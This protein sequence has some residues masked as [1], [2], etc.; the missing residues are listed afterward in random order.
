MPKGKSNTNV[1]QLFFE[2]APDALFLIN[3]DGFIEQINVQATLLFGYSREE[4]IGKGVE[5]LLPLGLRDGHVN[6]RKLYLEKPKLRPMGSGL[7]LQGRAKNGNEFPIDVSLSPVEYD[8][9]MMIAAAVRDF[10]QQ[11]AAET[12]LRHAKERAQAA[13]ASKSRFLAAASHDLRQPLQS[14]N[15]YIATL[16]RQTSEVTVLETAGKMHQS[17]KAM[18]QLL[19]SLLDLS[20]FEG[21]T[22]IPKI[23]EFPAQ[24]LL[25]QIYVDNA[26]IADEKRLHFNIAKSSAVISSDSQ[27]LQRVVENFVTNAIKYTDVGSV[28]IECREDSG[29]L[30]IEVVDTGIGIPESELESIFEAYEQL[31]NAVRDRRNGLGV[32]LTIARN[33]AHLLN[34]SI[35]VE[36]VSG[37]GSRFSVKVPLGA[38]VKQT[39][40]AQAHALHD[41]ALD[42]RQTILLIEDD[43]VVRDATK[44]FLDAA[45][46]HVIATSDA[47]IALD[48]VRGSGRPDLII[49][50]FCLPGID[51]Q[52]AIEKVR[53]HFGS[54]LPAILIT[55]DMSI[56]ELVD[57]RLPNCTVL[58]KPVDTNELMQLV[59]KHQA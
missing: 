46:H 21:G 49:S 5:N 50:D 24:V 13:T 29:S 6:Q 11:R 20:R 37:K 54:E 3:A 35:S 39:D 52:A 12:T 28:T 8:G 1:F 16:K 44:W 43:P 45:G 53:Q 23:E 22:I 26:P 32:G 47:E 40:K 15:L 59:D 7:Q 30:Y 36:S 14:L 17:L 42:D 41:D 56:R 18:G 58:S 55:G 10:T 27:L 9:Q 33:I 4:I 25:N 19:N 38:Q 57:E 31:H 2:A 34:H 48:I 51:G